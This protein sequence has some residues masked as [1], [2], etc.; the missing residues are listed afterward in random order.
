M[1]HDFRDYN[2]GTFKLEMG[3]Y[4]GGIQED[5]RSGF[6]SGGQEGFHKIQEQAIE[7]HIIFLPFD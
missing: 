2:D 3:I 7:I 6:I 5:V 4:G 1:H